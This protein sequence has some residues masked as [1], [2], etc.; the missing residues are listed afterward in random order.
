VVGAVFH[1][2]RE[3]GLEDCHGALLTFQFVKC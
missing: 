2:G 3:V 1:L